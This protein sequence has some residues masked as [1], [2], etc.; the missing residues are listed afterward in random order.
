MKLPIQDW[1]IG[2]AAL[3]VGLAVGC[4]A[5]IPDMQPFAD[6]TARMSSGVKR[7][8]GHVQTLLAQTELERAS[9]AKLDSTWKQTGSTLNALVAYST[10]LADLAK[11]G[12]QGAEAANRVA[13]ALDG[14]VTTLGFG[15]ILGP[16]TSALGAANDYIARVRARDALK[17]II[18]EA[19]PAV[20]TI[21]WIIRQ[22]LEEIENL[23][24]FAARD[25][26]QANL[27]KRQVLVNYYEG[28]VTEDQQVLRILTV[29][30][31]WETAVLEQNDVA[32][33]AQLEELGARDPRLTTD[34]IEERHA[35]WLARSQ[36]IQAEAQRYRPDYEAFQAGQEEIDRSQIAGGDLLRAAQNAMGAWARA[37]RRLEQSL[38]QEW[39][40][41]NL[42]DFAVAV[43]DIYDA[44]KG[45]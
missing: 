1:S 22:N 10:V 42:V 7:G 40:F 39:S 33:S 30:V 15:A 20:D 36:A 16:I 14:I 28:L 3:A 5:R 23:N 31:D 19:Q 34:N 29:F 21:A 6:Q 2:A 12:T 27:K 9:L 43:Q 4:S 8:Y 17:D 18:G 13:G 25:I 37:H 44:Y 45:G 41:V 35:Y 32:A 24:T 38:Q 11:T 26:K